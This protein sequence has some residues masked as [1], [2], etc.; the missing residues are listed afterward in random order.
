MTRL[1]LRRKLALLVGTTV[2]AVIAIESYLEI[3]TFERSVQ[4]DRLESAAATAQA[5]ADDLELRGLSETNQIHDLLHEFLAAT[6]ALRDIA[7]LAK[8]GDTLALIARTSSANADELLPAARQAIDRRELVWIDSGRE[9]VVATPV[10]HQGQVIG[11]VTVAVSLTPV[12]QLV[13]R[14]RQVTLW[15]AIPAVLLL[16]AL[17]DLLVRR[18]VHHPIGAIRHTMRRAGAGET[19]ARTVVERPDEIGEVAEGLNQMLEQLDR[20]HMELQTRVNEATAELRDTNA[21]LVDSYQR[22]LTLREAL[23]KAEQMAALGQLAA[24]VAHQIGTPLNLISGYVQVMMEEARAHPSALQRLQTVEAQIRKVTEAIRSMLDTAR[25][26]VVQRQP[27]DIAALVEQVCDVSRPALHAAHIE[28]RL[29]VQRP[30]PSLVADPVQLELALFNLVSNSLDAMPEGGR[31]E[32]AVT[33]TAEGIRLVVADSGTGISADVLPRIFEPWVTTKPAGRG[34]GLGLSIT[35][36][37]ITS[38]GGTI[39]VRSEPGRGA[40]FT[41]D[42][43]AADTPAPLVPPLL[44]R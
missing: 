12:E 24:N 37:T 41:I 43:P 29:D 14:G 1:S 34:T 13:V 36:E 2:A 20:F 10:I 17:V 31:L 3:S 21:R 26:P 35:R 32:I 5:V 16:T 27:V 28:L 9:R 23:A 42:L 25:R 30:L 6:P 22:V 11:A 15:F 44:N 19:G 39:D 38:H 8:Q 40:V 33:S 18:F 4:K 7:A